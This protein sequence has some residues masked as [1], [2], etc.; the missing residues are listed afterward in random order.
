MF[1]LLASY[2]VLVLTVAFLH[3]LRKIGVFH[4]HAGIAIAPWYLHQLLQQNTVLVLD[5]PLATGIDGDHRFLLIEDVFGWF[6]TVDPALQPANLVLVY[7]PS[8]LQLLIAAQA[9]RD[10]Y[11]PVHGIAVI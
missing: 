8:T 11:L 1:V 6:V 10:G 7:V 3:G 2:F 5:L 9:I 4:T